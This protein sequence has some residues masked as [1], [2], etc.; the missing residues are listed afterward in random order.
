MSRVS[1]KTM[2]LRGYTI[3][4]PCER[5]GDVR[6]LPQPTKHGTECVTCALPEEGRAIRA[7]HKRYAAGKKL[8]DFS[9]PPVTKDQA[10]AM[11]EAR[12]AEIEAFRP[13]PLPEQFAALK[14]ARAES[15]QRRCDD[16]RWHLWRAAQSRAFKKG[17]QFTI[18]IEDIVV[19]RV[20]PV[21]G[22]PLVHGRGKLQDSS[23]ALDRIV[24]TIGYTPGNVAV[25][26]RRANTVK[27]SGTAAEHRAIADWVD[28]WNFNRMLE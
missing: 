18:T 6:R 13:A 9:V 7:P 17:L 11:L 12:R 27:S 24:P 5:C 14:T 23:P 22:I 15:R 2:R 21:L 4:D 28:S 16:P 25:I 26:S 19:P 3:S 1:R 10:R 8:I 20:C